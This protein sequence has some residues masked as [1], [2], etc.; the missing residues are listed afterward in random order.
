MCHNSNIMKHILKSIFALIFV[1][2]SFSSCS[3]RQKIKKTMTEFM[4]TE[5][6][7]PASMTVVNGKEVKVADLSTLH[8]NRMIMF[9]DSMSCSSCRIGHFTDA[10]PL[11]EL[12]D[13]LKNFSVMAI[14]SPEQSK[15]V[16]VE[17]QLKL[18]DFPYPIYID[19]KREFAMMNDIPADKRFHDFMISKDGR[20]KYVGNPLNG[21]QLM[22]V[23][24]NTLNH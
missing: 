6:V 10:L 23:F 5:I 4:K 20:V 24:K 17:M 8:D 7:L 11:Y 12:S 19:T 15:L 1:C 18:L 9:V 3:E 16:D 14:F 22:L 2:L 13:S 21:E